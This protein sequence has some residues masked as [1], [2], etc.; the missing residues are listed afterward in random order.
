MSSPHPALLVP[1]ACLSLAGH[2][3]P[4]SLTVT[5]PWQVQV[6]AGEVQVDGTTI[7]LAAPVTLTVAPAALVT[8]T[9]ERYDSLPVFNPGG[10]GWMKGARLRGVI[11]QETSAK[12]ALEPASVL[13]TSEADGGITYVRDQDYALDPAWGT[14]GR[15]AG[16]RIGD[17]QP[18]YASYRHGLGRLDTI[19]VGRDG[20][21]VVRLGTP[22]I[23][24]PQPAGAGEE[25]VALANLWVSSRLGTLD[26][27]AVFPITEAAYP[28]LPVPQ[29]LADYC[30]QTLRKLRAGETVRILAWGD[31]VTD[32]GFLPAP[33]TERWQAQFVA[34]LQARFPQATIEL[35]NLG[36]G[37]RNTASFLGEPA[38]SRFNY[39]EKVLGAKPD[40]IVSEFVND[41]GLSPEAVEARYGKL[42]ADFQGIGAEWIIL[43]PHYVRPDWMSLTRERDI[44][45]DPRPYVAGLRQFAARHHVA[46]ADASL[47]WG[48]LWRQGLPYTTLLLNAINHPDRRGMAL[49]ADSLMALVPAE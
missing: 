20:R 39:R 15:L 27:N 29:T 25:A 6:G 21:V 1:L 13:L 5:G 10:A 8:V 47:R 34:R 42:L 11:T 38:G 36:W 19:A 16:G 18:V 3:A 31:S 26:A 37:G 7:T 44:D 4:P 23:S 9:G 41:A 12:G 30:P 48:R 33:A 40:L 24:V 17:M 43:T 49:F 22:H 28:A 2:A 14:F 35:I 46:L 45:A 32:G